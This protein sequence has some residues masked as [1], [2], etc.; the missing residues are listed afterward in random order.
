MLTVI[1]FACLSQKRVSKFIIKVT[2]TCFA[3]VSHSSQGLDLQ[4]WHTL[5]AARCMCVSVCLCVFARKISAFDHQAVFDC[6]IAAFKP[7]FDIASP[8]V[9]RYIIQQ[10]AAGGALTPDVAFMLLHV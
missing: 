9:F 10:E 6:I 3:E 5:V 4:N 2:P 1:I 8:F 7:C